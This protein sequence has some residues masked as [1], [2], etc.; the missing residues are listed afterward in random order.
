MNVPT[1]IKKKKNVT[2]ER[3]WQ[4]YSSKLFSVVLCLN[5]YINKTDQNSKD[6]LLESLNLIPSLK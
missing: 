4:L 2:A 6:N 5:K 1:L 3:L